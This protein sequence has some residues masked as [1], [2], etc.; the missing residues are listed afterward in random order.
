MAEHARYEDYA[1]KVAEAIGDELDAIFAEMKP[2][3]PEPKEI[4]EKDLPRGDEEWKLTIAK[5]HNG[6]RIVQYDRYGVA[7]W[8]AERMNQRTVE[9]VI[10]LLL[11]GQL[12]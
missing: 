7:E 6:F 9:R 10:W 8:D 4:G 3:S 5:R 2:S 12:P 11:K 1:V